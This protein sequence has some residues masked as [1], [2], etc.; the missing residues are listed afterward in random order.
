MKKELNS[1]QW[2]LLCDDI[3]KVFYIE[4]KQISKINE[5]LERE[6]IN[7]RIISKKGTSGELRNQTY[8]KTVTVEE[9]DKMKK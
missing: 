8:Y 2:K 5:G 7:A 1:S 3:R 9:F 4:G 6:G